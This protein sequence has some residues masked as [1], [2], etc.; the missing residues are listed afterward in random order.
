[1]RYDQQLSQLD[2][3]NIYE[4]KK[5]IIDYMKYSNLD[6]STQQHIIKDIV[7][8]FTILGNDFLPRIQII[9]TNKHIRN[10]FDAYNKLNFNITDINK[11][12]FIYELN[13]HNSY[14]LNF[15]NLK[16]FFINLKANINKDHYKLIRRTKDW[17]ILPN[18]IINSNAL[19][20]YQHIFNIE[21]LVNTYEPPESDSLDTYHIKH[22]AIMKYLVGFMWL[23]DY[24]LNHN[25]KHEFFYYKYQNVP[26]L[27]QLINILNKFDSK[28]ELI[29]KLKSNLKSTTKDI[30]FTPV[31]QLVYIS[32]IT[33][34]N[35]VDKK[36][37]D[38]NLIKNI[39]TYDQKY[40]SDIDLQIKNFKINLFDYL[41]C[42][43]ALYLSKC[44]LKNI[45][46]ISGYK[47]LKL[48]RSQR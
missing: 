25:M 23:G 4:L 31:E 6:K 21:N 24:Y 7:M 15:P 26:T 16:Q 37:L 22:K 18:Q 5:N 30:Y 13:Q 28:P 11:F 17:K 44:E 40:I 46:K 27:D 48:L 2:M 29:N 42:S 35:I 38:S 41:D 14:N 20:Y 39:N 9:N 8:L 36:L 32:P 34:F 43:E 10:I 12:K 19:G 47:I 1:M 45:K 33:I 3:I